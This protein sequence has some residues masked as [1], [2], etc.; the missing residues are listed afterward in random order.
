MTLKLV[1][2]S[3]ALGFSPHSL[4]V[5]GNRIIT[6]NDADGKVYFYDINFNLVSVSP[7]SGIDI[8][9]LVYD[10]RYFYVCDVTNNYIRVYCARCNTLIRSIELDFVPTGITFDGKY[11]YVC[12]ADDDKIYKY[13]NNFKLIRKSAEFTFNPDGLAFLGKDLLIC[14]NTN[15]KLFLY[16][17]N[18]NQIEEV[19]DVVYNPADVAFDGYF[20]YIADSDNNLIKKYIYL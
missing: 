18:F 12:N 8:A 2:Q 17:I 7:N 13:D 19:F 20:I 16:D 9:S 3:A 6:S 11:F 15:K 14:D 5:L 1:S 10:G 4:E